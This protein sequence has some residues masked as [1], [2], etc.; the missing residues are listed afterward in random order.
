MNVF[1]TQ[2][3]LSLETRLKTKTDQKEP[4]SLK[5]SRKKDC[6]N[7]K[8]V[9][10]KIKVEETLDDFESSE[11]VRSGID[12][13]AIHPDISLYYSEVI[14]VAGD[15][16]CGFRCL[17][18][19]LY[20]DE[21]QFWKVKM[22]MRDVLLS[23][24]EFYRTSFGQYMTFEELKTVVCFGLEEV[25]GSDV[26]SWSLF[27]NEMYDQTIVS[28]PSDCW[29]YTSGCTQL[30]ADTF[31]RPVAAYAERQFKRSP[32]ELFLPFLNTGKF[33]SVLEKSEVKDPSPIILHNIGRL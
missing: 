3:T 7:D 26:I 22:K 18:V 13:D 24:E 21:N 12:I 9:I 23:N 31:R 17:A 6:S 16:F 11:S 4:L 32:P 27:Y 15:G 2:F 33:H 8:A 10:K 14:D 25:V 30:A 29:F 1:F 28:A 5:K 20:G 19:D